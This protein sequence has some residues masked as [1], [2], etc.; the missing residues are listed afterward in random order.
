MLPGVR[1]KPRARICC[2]KPNVVVAAVS[3][4]GIRPPPVL[5]EVAAARIP[6]A[7]TP[8][9]ERGESFDRLADDEHVCVGVWCD[10]EGRARPIA[11]GG[12]EERANL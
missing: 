5:T 6:R 4:G 3:I 7:I 11:L 2:E 12:H 1:E 8:Q 10:K 9:H